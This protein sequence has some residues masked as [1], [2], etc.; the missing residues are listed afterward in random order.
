VASAWPSR[1]GQVPSTV[2]QG[3]IDNHAPPVCPT[4]VGLLAPLGWGYQV[5][6]VLDG[7]GAEQ[8]LPVV[9][10]GLERERGGDREYLGST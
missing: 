3:S 9:L 8:E 10:A 5:R 7:A 4:S 1:S 6:L 2:Y